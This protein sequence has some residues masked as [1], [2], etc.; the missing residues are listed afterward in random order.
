[1]II[2]IN[3]I[4]FKHLNIIQIRMLLLHYRYLFKWDIKNISIVF[5]DKYLNLVSNKLLNYIQL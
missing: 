5:E 2:F 4:S 3:F 1:M